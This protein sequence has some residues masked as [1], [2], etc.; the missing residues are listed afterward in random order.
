MRRVMIGLALLAGTVLAQTNVDPNER[1]QKLVPV[2]YVDPNA[3]QMLL[4][5]FGV[6][7]RADQ[8]LRTMALSGKRTAVTTAE[9]AI[10]QLDVPGAA[11]KD[12]E[13]TVYFVVGAEGPSR[14]GCLRR[15]RR[16]SKAP[17]RR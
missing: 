14:A 15:S 6:E 17:S 12:V 11:Q 3:V 16:R 7:M 5:N 8:R 13:L 1:V 9:D 4:M 10:K 2:K